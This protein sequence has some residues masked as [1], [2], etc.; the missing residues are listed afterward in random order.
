MSITVDPQQSSSRDS[1]LAA[2]AEALGQFGSQDKRPSQRDAQPS[3]LERTSTRDPLAQQP[4]AGAL[5]RQSSRGGLARW[6]LGSLLIVASILVAILAWQ[7]PAGHAVGLATAR[8]VQERLSMSSVWFEK[9]ERLAWPV[10]PRPNA[11]DAGRPQLSSETPAAPQQA[12]PAVA[13]ISP[14][15]TARLQTIGRELAD[16]QQAIEQFKTS[17]A[18]MTQD[19]AGLTER[20][21]EM[22][23]QM[24]RQNG[25]LGDNLRQVQVEMRRGI[26]DAAAQLKASQDQMTGLS[27]QL[28]ATQEQMVRLAAPKP[29][30]SPPRR[31]PI[32]PSTH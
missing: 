2:L 27:Q 4:R 22:Q 24:A 14:E 20:L 23:E 12:A 13:P 7:S 31:R 25:E 19:D 26:A 21:K 11:T 3:E 8:W 17:Q 18:Q 6:S 30:P 1:A 32:T 15:L 28:K 29:Q 5:G 16:L 10:P 9:M